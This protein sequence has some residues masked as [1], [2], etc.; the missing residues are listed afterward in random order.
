MTTTIRRS[1]AGVLALG[2]LALVLAAC[3]GDD[4]PESGTGE[5]TLAFGMSAEPDTLDPHVHGSRSAYS[6]DRQIFDTLIVRDDESNDFVPSLASEWE[7]SDDGTV[8]TFTLREGITFHDGTPFDAEAVVFNLDRVVDPATQSATAKDILGPYESSRAIDER[9]VE[10]RFSS[11]TSPV[12]ILDALSQA[13]LGMVSPA[14]VEQHGD[15]FGRNPVGTGPFK[16]EQWVAG[17]QVTLSRNEDYDWAPANA[18]REGPPNLAQV[19]FRFMDDPA[20]RVAALESG[21]L[22]INQQV[23]PTAASRLRERDDVEIVDGVAP[24]FP[25]CI[26]MNVEAGP[27]TDIN[28]RKAILHAFDRDTMIESVWQGEYRPAYGPLSPTSWAY[29][30]SVE[31]MYPYDVDRA[32]ELLDE[33]GWTTGSDGIRTKDGKRLEVRFF[34]GAEPRR[35]EYLQE[36]LRRVGIDLIVRVVDFSELFAVTRQAET[37]DMASTWFASSDPSILNV[38]F[39]SSNVEEGFAISRLRDPDIDERLQRGVTIVDEAEREELYKELQRDIMEMALLVPMYSETELDG[40]RTQFQGYELE[41]GQYP[42]LYGV[43]TD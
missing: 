41:R 27:L 34:D 35:G 36:N 11:T 38:L 33:A 26:W 31:D 24:G 30:K 32:N 16:F 21:D 25:V 15:Q 12:A 22:G 2:A 43:H 10:V 13:Y 7:F 5:A 3:G 8:Y 14:A 1:L 40:V 4:A 29:D 42:L 17:Q 9:T 37:Y 18:G 20:T 23:E 28:V 39:L 19:V 6:I